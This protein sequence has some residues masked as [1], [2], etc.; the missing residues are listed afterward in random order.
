MEIAF[1]EFCI[2]AVTVVKAM[3]GFILEANKLKIT[4]SDRKSDNQSK[5]ASLSRIVSPT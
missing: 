4:F 1:T 2:K 5:G 3:N